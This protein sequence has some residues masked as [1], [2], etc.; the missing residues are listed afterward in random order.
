M[1]FTKFDEL[2]CALTGKKTASCEVAEK[3]RLRG[4]QPVAPIPDATFRYVG[5]LLAT[6]KIKPYLTCA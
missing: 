5:I 2:S 3:A 4:K 1:H 6:F